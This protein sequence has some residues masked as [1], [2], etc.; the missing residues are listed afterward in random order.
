M[1]TS[2]KYF[3]SAVMLLGA[4]QANA[5][6]ASSI[7]TAFCQGPNS[8]TLINLEQG[9]VKTERF[10]SST[11]KIETITI[12]PSGNLITYTEQGSTVQFKLKLVSGVYDGNKV[13]AEFYVGNTFISEC[14]A[15]VKTN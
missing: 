2:F 5:S 1:K 13:A 9:Y 4:L 7:T 12:D 6:V 15:R 14:D 10:S 8:S 3:L 11:K